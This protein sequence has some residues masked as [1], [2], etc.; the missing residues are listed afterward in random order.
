MKDNH[1]KYI[2]ISGATSGL[3]YECALNWIEKGGS[4]ILIARNSHKLQDIQDKLENIKPKSNQKIITLQ[5]DAKKIEDLN[6]LTQSLDNILHEL[7]IIAVI[8]CIGYGSFKQF[9]LFTTNEIEEMFKVNTFSLI[10]LNQYFANYMKN[11]GY[12]HIFNIASMAGKIATP[13]SSIYSASKSAVI[14]FSN[15]LRLEVAKYNIKITTVNLGPMDTNFFEIADPSGEYL[16]NL[17]DKLIL[18][19]KIVAQKIIKNINKNKREINL[20]FIMN[21]GYHAY[22]LFP[23]IGDFLTR[24]IFNKK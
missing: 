12:G 19:P 5:Y 20:P 7:N 4:C 15:T 2:I 17:N 9:D 11:Q 18:N 16:K 24:T 13:K 22:N 21:L 6:N 8:N 3:G 14:S 1:K 10:H 23:K